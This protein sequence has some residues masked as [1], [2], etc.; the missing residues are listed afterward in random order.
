VIA[1]SS[2]QRLHSK[3]WRSLL[4]L[5]ALQLGAATA[6]AD[7]VE[8]ERSLL[9][10]SAHAGPRFATACLYDC[11]DLPA[12]LGMGLSGG[13]RMHPNFAAG[14]VGEHARFH[15]PVGPETAIGYTLLGVFARGYLL[16]QGRV[17][18]F[19]EIAFVG[20]VPFNDCGSRTEG[21]GG[22]GYRAAAGGAVYVVKWLEVGIAASYLG[23]AQGCSFGGTLGAGWMRRDD[24]PIVVAALGV[25]GTVTLLGP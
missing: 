17:D 12:G 15:S 8:G 11:P 7:D 22:P 10:L 19:L 21:G 13:V 4:A 25:D 18:T 6:R 16:A 24:T 23:T 14:F 20:A 1:I 2:F 5:A 9:E 3:R